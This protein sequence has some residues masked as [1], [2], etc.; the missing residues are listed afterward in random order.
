MAGL[1]RP[2]FGYYNPDHESLSNRITGMNQNTVFKSIGVGTAPNV[3]FFNAHWI[4]PTE[5][6]NFSQ[7]KGINLN[8]GGRFVTYSLNFKGSYW[9][10]QSKTGDEK[11]KKT[12]YALTAGGLFKDLTVNV[13]LIRFIE[14]L[15]LSL[16][17]GNVYTLDTKVSIF[18]ERTTR[19]STWHEPTQPSQK[20]R[21]TPPRWV[22]VTKAICC[23][24]SSLSVSI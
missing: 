8:M 16:N 24:A 2:M 5:G 15:P 1:Y 10:T 21:A 12:L 14:R 18:G 11:S 20:A 23:L 22:W 19:F 7:N 9:N 6:N 17:R 4:I 3:P 13:E